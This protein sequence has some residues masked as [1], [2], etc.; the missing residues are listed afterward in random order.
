MVY[1]YLVGWA[2]N[3][4]CLFASTIIALLLMAMVFSF[5]LKTGLFYAVSASS[6]LPQSDLE[7]VNGTL[8]PD[9]APFR[10]WYDWV[11]VSG[12]QVIYYA[13]YTTPDYPYPVP[14]ANIIGQHFSLVDGTQVFIA[15][16]LSELEVY[17][18]LNGDGVP[19]DNMGSGESEIL[20]YIYSN[21]S[22]GYSMTPIQKT[23]VDSV[24]HYQWSFS[25]QNAYAYLQNANAR[26]GVIA[27]MLFEHLTLSYDFSVDGNISSLKTSFDVG[28]VANLEI[29]DPSQF[30]SFDGLSLALLYATATYT[31]TSYSTSVNGQPYDSSTADS[32]L[33]AEVAE[34][35]V[36]DVKAYDFLFGGTYTLN[37][38]G[39]G[40]NYQANVETFEAE[41]QAVPMV[42]LPVIYGPT[43]RS[44]SFFS[45]Q[46]NLA[47][48]F[49]GSWPSVNSNYES[50]SLIY[51]ICFPVWGGRQIEHDPTFVGYIFT[52]QEIPELPIALVI[53]ALV[54]ATSMALIFRSKRK[55]M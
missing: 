39:G 53:A 14:I 17:R 8:V 2:L 42:G 4:K 50:S 49:G 19:Q 6:I 27:R 12:T 45:D 1:V 26:V 28:K 52:N 16:A 10:V 11:N 54:I 20:Y 55:L 48:L 32:A 7:Y 3:R 34:V 9:Y 44:I 29:L 24:P 35:K 37:G 30:S 21:M 31:S 38:D 46:L 18:D 23:T 43:V 15:S 13:A 25:Y 36:E 51:R 33:E 40:E 41:A 22:Q 5:S 47:D